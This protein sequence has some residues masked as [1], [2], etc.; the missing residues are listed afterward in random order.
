MFKKWSILL[1][2]ALLIVPFVLTACGDDEKEDKKDDKKTDLAVK[3]TQTFTNAEVGVT[4][5]YPDGWVAREDSAGV[6]LASSQAAMDTETPGENDQVIN[7][8]VN[9]LDVFGATT[10]DEVITLFKQAMTSEEE[11]VT[12][13]EVTS[14]KVGSKD[15]KRMTMT[16]PTEGEAVFIAWLTED[17]KSVVSVMGIA[18]NGKLSAL[19]PNLLAVANSVTYTPP[20]E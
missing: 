7:V 3:L 12:I 20:A 8:E 4:V 6:S 19:E 5:Q 13:S 11:G 9:A 10:L 15:A 2:I 18:T 17:G 16:H 14:L 1:L